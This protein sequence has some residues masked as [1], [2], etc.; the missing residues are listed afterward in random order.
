MPLLPKD[1]GTGLRE[2][3][4]LSQP[5]KVMARM[6]I[7]VQST[8]NRLQIYP[9]TQQGVKLVLHHPVPYVISEAKL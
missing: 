5:R 3:M 7:Q 2:P 8:Y 4:Y 9:E 6:R 1:E